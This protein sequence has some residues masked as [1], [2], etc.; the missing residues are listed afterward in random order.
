MI[1]R[2]ELRIAVSYCTNFLRTTRDRDH[3]EVCD[4]FPVR[5]A[6]RS[7]F[8][9]Y[10]RFAIRRSDNFASRFVPAHPSP[11]PSLSH[12]RAGM[13]AF[14]FFFIIE[15]SFLLAKSRGFW[16]APC[17]K[18]LRSIG[19]IRQIDWRLR[20]PA[21]GFGPALRRDLPEWLKTEMDFLGDIRRILY[22]N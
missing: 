18:R 7:A 20:L 12:Y 1:G 19:A 8:L 9:R 22:P 2:G 21:T 17:Q 5:D 15:Y 13:L 11:S 4:L 6:S 3:S 14:L 16:S 10:C